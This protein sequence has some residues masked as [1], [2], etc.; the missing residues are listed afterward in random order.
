[1]TSCTS[2]TRHFLG[3][4]RNGVVVRSFDMIAF[5]LSPSDMEEINSLL[6]S[7]VDAAA[8]R[9]VYK[10]KDDEYRR[11]DLKGGAGVD[12]TKAVI[13]RVSSKGVSI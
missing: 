1:M 12:L 3:R 4:N 8:V 13:A 10:I 11:L 2:I 5:L 9:K 7:R 6:S